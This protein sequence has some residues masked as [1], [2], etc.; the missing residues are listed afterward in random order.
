MCTESMLVS[1]SLPRNLRPSLLPKH[2]PSILRKLPL[3]FQWLPPH[4][5]NVAC[6]A[7]VFIVHARAADG[8]D[9]GLVFAVRSPIVL[10]WPLGIGV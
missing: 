8:W 5:Q 2:R 4:L 6:R 3:R 1:P 9:A 10:V 7:G